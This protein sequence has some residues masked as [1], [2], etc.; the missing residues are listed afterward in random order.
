MCSIIGL[1][2]PR[3]GLDDHSRVD[4]VRI[5]MHSRTAPHR[6][7]YRTMESRNRPKVFGEVAAVTGLRAER[8]TGVYYSQGSLRESALVI[9]VRAGSDRCDGGRREAQRIAE[10][11]SFRAI[12]GAHRCVPAAHKSHYGR[13]IPER[14]DSRQRSKHPLG[15]GEDSP[16]ILLPTLPTTRASGLRQLWNSHLVL[17]GG[18]SSACATA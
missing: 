11:N 6:P 14:Q 10:P 16:R 13:V 7:E 5:G 2:S 15:P 12:N 1:S 17:P 4:V 9:W 3:A 18:E 8:L